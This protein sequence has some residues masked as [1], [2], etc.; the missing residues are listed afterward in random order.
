M[1]KKISIVVPVFNGE[2]FFEKSLQSLLAQTLEDLEII[3]I[4]DG[5]TDGTQKIIDAYQERYP[6][7]IK[8]RLVENGGAGKARNYALDLAEGEYIGFFDSDDFIAKDMYE[9]LYDEAIRKEADIVVC[10]YYVATNTSLRS[11]QKGSMEVY[12]QSIFD[13]PDMFVYGVPYLWNKIFKRSMIEK[14][15]IRFHDFR[16]F[17]DL[18]FTYRLFFLANRIVKVDEPLYYYMKLNADSLTARFTE[19]FFDIIPAMKSLVSFARELGVYEQFKD[20][21]LFIYMNH[22]YIRMNANV[23]FSDMK[24]KY[25]YIDACFDYMEEEFPN[26]RAHDYYFENKK[27]NKRRYVSRGYWKR[28]S[29]VMKVSKKLRRLKNRTKKMFRMLIKR[30]P[31][32]KYLKYTETCP[33]MKNW[34]LL[35]S[36]HG[37]D[38]NGNMFYLLKEL[39]KDQYAG[40]EVYVTVAKKRIEEF[41]RKL[42]FY[43]ISR[44]KLLIKESNQYLK[45]LAAAGYLFNDTSFPTFFIKRKEQVYFN[46]WHGTPLKT[47]GKK[48]RE[49]FYN[50]GNLQKNFN[51]A[52]YLLYPSEYM[53]EHMI[54]DYM[55]ANISHNKAALIGYPRNAIFFDDERRAQIRHQQGLDG[56]TVISYMPTWRGTLNNQDNDDYVEDLQKKL[57]EISRK[58]NADQVL[59]LNVH[60][61]LKDYI[62]IDGFT[63]VFMFPKEYETYDFLNISDILITDYSSVF[64]DFA[65]TGRRIL[66]FAYDKEAYMRE[67]GLYID[68]DQLPFPMVETVDALI[69]AINDLSSS[70]YA[71][72]VETYARYDS[73][74]VNEK[75]CE[76]IILGKDKGITLM[77]IPDNHRP[78]VLCVANDLSSYFLNETFFRLADHSDTKRYNYYLTYINANLYKHKR[79]L[80]RLPQGFEYYGQLFK[81][82]LASFTDRAVLWALPR[83]QSVCS[84]FSCRLERIFEMERNRLFNDIDFSYTLV[85]GEKKNIRLLLFA[86]MKGKKI[87]Y[88]P[89]D[90]EFNDNV[91]PLVYRKYDQILIEDPKVAEAAMKKYADC[92]IKKIAKASSLDELL[93]S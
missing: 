4:N 3:I 58:L 15:Q 47:L 49:D 26:W 1:G 84:R 22:M 8:S 90:R 50:I 85:V 82:V 64:F 76:Q 17:E 67:R 92:A 72:F 65:C 9:K 70:S 61:Y 53:M 87:L 79:E 51:V 75:I 93:E 5:S 16:I 32:A 54:E 39:Q 43:G 88:V 18:E 63:N 21:L 28:M 48:T 36:Q 77:D 34:I 37:E 80:L 55:L 7:K 13:Q 12:G 29:L 41:K 60:P 59:Y 6:D 73:A 78:N 2:A 74:D 14:N 69:D 83:F 24:L 86:Q 23:S 91:S 20:Y 68:F 66:L 40:F 11:Y 27:R 33:V 45:V 44:V 42:D 71:D 62:Q 57:T 81:F 10:G 19:R 38:L 25:K 56:K 35:D 30:K 46:T 89:Y 31:G 52:D